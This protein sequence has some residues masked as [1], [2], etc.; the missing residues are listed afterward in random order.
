MFLIETSA[1]TYFKKDNVVCTETEE[2]RLWASLRDD[3]RVKTF[4]PIECE[5]T[6]R[7]GAQTQTFAI[8]RA[9]GEIGAK[10]FDLRNVNGTNYVTSVKSQMINSEKDSKLCW[11][12]STISVVESSYLVE[13]GPTIDLSERHIGFYADRILGDGTTNVFGYNTHSTTSGE[14]S[15]G[16]FYLSGAYLAQRRGPIVDSKLP[17]TT[18]TSSSQNTLSQKQDYSVNNIIY[19]TAENCQSDNAIANIKKLLTT[20]GAVGSYMNSSGEYLSLDNTSFYY[21][22]NEPY[23]HAMTIIGW[24]DDYSKEHFATT[25]SGMPPGNGAWIVKDTYPDVFGGDILQAGYHYTSYYDSDACKSIFSASNISTDKSDNGYYYDNLGFSDNIIENSSK[26][27][28]YFKEVFDKKSSNAELLNKVNIFANPGD[29]YEIYYSRTD[30]FGDAIKIASGIATNVG[31]KTLTVG[32]PVIITDSKFY[33]Y[34]KYTSAN[35]YVE[36]GQTYYQFPAFLNSQDTDSFFHLESMKSGV[37]YYGLDTSSEWIDTTANSEFQFY[38]VVHVFTNNVDYNIVVQT[39]QASQEKITIKG[40]GYFYI[41]LS[42]ANIS[43]LND[44]TVKVYDSKNADATEKFAIS[45]YQNGFKISPKENEVQ[46]GIYRT[47]FSYRSISATQDITILANDD[48]KVTKVTIEDINNEVTVNGTLELTASILPTN[49]TIKSIMWTSL[50]P[51]IAT[52][53]INGTVRGVKAGEVTIRATAKD[54]TGINDN[55]LVKVIDINS[56]EGNG[57]TEPLTEFLKNDTV[58]TPKPSNVQDKVD[59]PTTGLWICTG[60][61]IF[62]IAF[63]I[64]L[65]VLNEKYNL[66]RQFR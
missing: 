10:S 49:A 20:Y 13:G 53:G 16:N 51:S 43:S 45:V 47:V 59:N 15:G 56:L 64:S 29:S 19:L 57:T 63:S 25:A 24:D 31:Y 52:V 32:T 30:S 50:D 37:S 21:N 61:F 28:I 7:I 66:F 5:E 42:L 48:I 44:I 6:I 60:A 1:L 11:G 34:T 33:I 27:T 17:I 36:E 58:E 2:H 55:Y 9:L 41:P 4:E 23:G 62:A 65:L 14:D 12:F 39:P 22:G 8:T 3:E 46:A 54:G 35:S 26:K 40:D 38:P 18:L